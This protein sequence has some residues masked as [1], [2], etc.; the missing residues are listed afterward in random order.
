V[1]TGMAA[2]AESA[3]QICLAMAQLNDSS[4][5]TTESVR[6]ANQAITLLG[7]VAQELQSEVS[8]FR[9]AV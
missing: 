7:S 4:Q 9:V 8:N 3:Q 2:Q 1:T 6:E 5:Q